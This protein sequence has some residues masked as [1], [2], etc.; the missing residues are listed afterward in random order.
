M[1]EKPRLVIVDAN[2]IEADTTCNAL[3]PYAGDV[4]VVTGHD[5][6]DPCMHPDA[7]LIVLELMMPERDGIEWIRDLS[8]R[9]HTPELILYTSASERIGAAAERLAR[10]RGLKVRRVIHKPDLDGLVQ[11]VVGPSGNGPDD[12]ESDPFKPSEAQLR[13]AIGDGQISVL[14]Q[15]KIAVDTLAPIS[16][17]ALARWVH[18]DH[19]PVSPTQFIKVAEYHALIGPLTDAVIETSFASA[20]KWMADGVPLRLA[21]NVSGASLENLSLPDHIAACAARHEL[22]PERITVEI[23]ETWF[24]QY[25]IDAL[26]IMTRLRMKGFELAI[27]D[28]GTGHSTML[29]LKQVPFSELKLDQS[30]IRGAASDEVARSIVASSIDLGHALGLSVIAEGVDNQDDWALISELGCDAGQGYFLARPMTAAALSEWYHR[31]RVNSG[32]T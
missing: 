4:T 7:D 31:W 16:V 25:P 8:E 21:I 27:D 19:G 22:A 30:L 26:D 15:P 28:F 32:A 2:R 12:P 5:R 18:A 23:T 9:P 13:H 14:F 17:E 24:E 3:A 6:A 10:S 1:P 11:A 20:R 29:R